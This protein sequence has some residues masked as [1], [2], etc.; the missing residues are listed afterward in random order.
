MWDP[1]LYF[2]HHRTVIYKTV[3][4]SC[5]GIVRNAI[6]VESWLSFSAPEKMEP[7]DLFW[8]HIQLKWYEYLNS[9]G[10]MEINSSAWFGRRILLP[11]SRYKWIT[12]VSPFRQLTSAIKSARCLLYCYSLI[13]LIRAK[14]ITTNGTGKTLQRQRMPRRL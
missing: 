9:V 10:D 4:I 3:A 6:T 5:S 14:L 2:S 11:L 13:C 1:T 8:G 12:Q 7:H